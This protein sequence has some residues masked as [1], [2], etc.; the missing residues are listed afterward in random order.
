MYNFFASR[1]QNDN[2]CYPLG[3]A[4]SLRDTSWAFGSTSEGPANLLVGC[5]GGP[6]YLTGFFTL[7]Y[8]SFR[9]D[10]VG[11]Y[12]P[13]CLSVAD[14]NKGH[15]RAYL[16]TFGSVVLSPI[17]SRFAEFSDYCVN[18]RILMNRAHPKAIERGL[19][20]DIDGMTGFVARHRMFQER[21]VPCDSSDS[22]VEAPFRMV[23]WPTP[24]N[25]KPF[26]EAILH[27]HKPA[28]VMAF[29]EGC[30]N[31]IEPSE[32]VQHLRGSIARVDFG[33]IHKVVG[34]EVPASVFL[35]LIDQIVVLKH[36]KANDL[37]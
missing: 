15:Y 31:L 4:D 18:M 8:T 28:P 33:L 30:S 13:N 26:H 6:A 20:T 36:D 11:G 35:A 12:D 32:Y 9:L 1:H 37:I 25:C 14:S 3:D 21:A 27:T 5:D 34:Q 19:F 29:V 16:E 23:N 22:E 10:A 2:S 24:A 17:P 7:D